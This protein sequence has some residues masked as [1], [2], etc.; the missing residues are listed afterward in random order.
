MNRLIRPSNLI[1]L[2]CKSTNW[3]PTE[4][5]DFDVAD[6]V[7]L[8]AIRSQGYTHLMPGIKKTRG[9]GHFVWI[10]EVLGHPQSS[11]NS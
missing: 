6:L 9:K 1:S 7:D 8:S 5:D 4:G 11:H 3:K 2:A 10:S